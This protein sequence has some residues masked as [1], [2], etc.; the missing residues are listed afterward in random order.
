MQRLKAVPDFTFTL[1]WCRAS[2]PLV[3]MTAF[4]K[5]AFGDPADIGEMLLNYIHWHRV[6]G[7]DHF[8]V[9]DRYGQMLAASER[10]TSEWR[11]RYANVSGSEAWQFY[12]L[13]DYI[14]AG[15]V[16][17]IPAPCQHD[18]GALCERYQDHLPTGETALSLAR[19]HTRWML[20]SDLDEFVN[21]VPRMPRPEPKG[22]I[23][24]WTPFTSLQINDWA[25]QSATRQLYYE[26]QCGNSLYCRSPIRDFLDSYTRYGIVQYRTWNVGVAR[27]PLDENEVAQLRV[28]KASGAA[29]LA[30][31]DVDAMVAR[32]H[33]KV[34]HWLYKDT[35]WAGMHEKYICQ[36]RLVQEVSSA[37]H[38]LYRTQR[39]AQCGSRHCH[40]SSCVLSQL[41]LRVDS[42]A[43][44][45]L[46]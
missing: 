13:T 10:L 39:A 8:Y 16:T 18:D 7:V 15:V 20:Q 43:C 41:L 22:E 9:F 19:Q 36:P 12:S 1:P 34:S 21:L 29:G 45:T 33:W 25:Q 23:E 4:I 44:T 28:D 2:R 42:G 35:E 46:A 14:R 31:V 17:Y 6:V 32:R 38:T 11:T 26:R 5:P 37:V 30:D 3:Y 27:D 24:Q 40:R